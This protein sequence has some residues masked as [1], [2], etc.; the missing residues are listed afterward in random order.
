MQKYI[1]APQ[2]SLDL[3]GYSMPCSDLKLYIDIAKTLIE[4][5]PL[6]IR[7]L[8]QFLKI[9]HDSLKKRM[10]FLSDQGLIKEKAN[11]PTSIYAIT[12]RGTKVLRFFRV[13]TSV[14]VKMPKL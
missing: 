3:K 13:K 14:K 5:G 10:N 4:N 8:S 11:N 9:D 2:T 1:R 12:K 7:E 6:N